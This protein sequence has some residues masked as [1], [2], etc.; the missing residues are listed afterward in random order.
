[1]ESFHST[2]QETKLWNT[3]FLDVIGKDQFTIK[4]KGKK[5]QITPKGNVKQL[6]MPI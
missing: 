4:G 1:M 6:Q 2:K 5:F 3:L